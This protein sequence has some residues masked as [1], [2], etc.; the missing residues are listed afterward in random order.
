MTALWIIGTVALI[1]TITM[2]LCKTASITDEQDEA[3]Y[4]QWAREREEAE[5]E[6]T[7]TDL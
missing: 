7:D 3:W 1:V 5:N 4:E 2:A 6:T